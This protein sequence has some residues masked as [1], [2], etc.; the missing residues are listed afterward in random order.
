MAMKGSGGGGY[1]SV[2]MS[3]NQS[4]LAAVVT[5]LGRPAFRRSAIRSATIRLIDPAQ[6]D[7]VARSCTAP[8]VTLNSHRSEITSH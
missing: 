2:R 1:G 3:R 6:A 8:S 4:R 7:I 5:A